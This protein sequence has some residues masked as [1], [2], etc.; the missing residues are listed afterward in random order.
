MMSLPL[1]NL[2][3]MDHIVS[4]EREILSAERKRDCPDDVLHEKW[5][6]E[7]IVAFDD[8]SGEALD[9]EQ[10]RK[11]RQD[12]IA[13]FKSMKVYEKVPITEAYDKTGKAPIQCRWIDV[14]KGDN[15]NPLYRS[16][17]VA[18]EFKTDVR[19]DLYAATPP[20]E[21]LK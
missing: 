11:A 9:L 20:S 17:L 14:N 1:L 3:Q 7:A 8:L 2:E 15:S 21:C 16:R 6:P 5:A 19:P 12:E 18:K 4:E 10:V 13:Y